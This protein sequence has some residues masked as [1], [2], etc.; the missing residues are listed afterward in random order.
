MKMRTLPWKLLGLS[1]GVVV[2]AWGIYWAVT[3]YIFKDNPAKGGQFGDTFGCLNTLFAGLAFAVVFATLIDQWGRI[4]DIKRD[5]QAERRFRLRLDLFDERFRIYR[6]ASDFIG[7]VISGNFDGEHSDGM[8]RMLDFE[9]AR[10]KAYFL[11]QGDSA[12]LEYLSTLKEEAHIYSHFRQQ[13]KEQAQPGG[14]ASKE[15]DEKL[16]WFF[17]QQ[18]SL[19]H[20][21]LRYLSFQEFE[22]LKT[23]GEESMM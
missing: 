5:A 10:E 20:K 22:D 14:P 17:A 2:A 1:C 8:K 6:A 19:R 3:F 12:L 7:N 15:R 13:A 11:F 16:K 18:D 21:F 23:R 4:E 9:S